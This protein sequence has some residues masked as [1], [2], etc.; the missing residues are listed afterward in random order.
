MSQIVATVTAIKSEQNLNIVT[1][2]FDGIKLKMM[3]LELPK[4]LKNGSKVSLLLKP[5]SVAIGK[6]VWGMLSYSN[7]FSA[8]IADIEVGKLLT[9]LKLQVRQHFIDSMITK[10]SFQRMNLQKG[11]VVTVFI[12]ASELSIKEVHND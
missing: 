8:S 12:K 10:D 6:D 7:S 1:F 11:E 4:G 2:D 5:S 9:I 3:S